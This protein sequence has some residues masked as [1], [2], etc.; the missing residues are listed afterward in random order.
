MRVVEVGGDGLVRCEG[1][2]EVMAALV[3]EV[4][5]GDELLV[6]AGVALVKLA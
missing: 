2:V 5:P 1:D 6:H 4:E 3:G